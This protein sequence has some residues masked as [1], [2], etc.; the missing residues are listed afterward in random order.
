MRL[1][2]YI[3]VLDDRPAGVGVYIEEVCSRLA[4]RFRDVVVYTGTP[5]ARRP[6]LKGAVV[7]PLGRRLAPWLRGAEGLRRRA[8]RLAWLAGESVLDLR[9]DGVDVLFSPVQESLLVGKTPRV[10]VVHDVTALHYPDAYDA[11]TVAQ[12][13]YLLPLMLRR[14]SRVIAVSENTKRDVVARFGLDPAGIDVVY[15]GYDKAVFRPRSGAEIAEVREKFGLPQR[16]LFYAGTFSRHKN[17]GL[18]VEALAV[19]RDR[20]PD[21]TFVVAGRK[22]AGVAHEVVDRSRALGLEEKVRVLGYVS[23]DE[24]ATLM[25][26]AAVFVYPSRYEG[27]GLAPLEAMACGAPVVASNVASLPEVV[28]QGGVLVDGT[29][30]D[31]W[32]RAVGG[33][34]QGDSSALRGRALRQSAA[35][36]W[37]GAVEALAAIV[38]AA[39]AP[40]AP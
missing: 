9:R 27:F 30:S 10:V 18:V 36:T 19:L 12:T 35:F 13:R 31:A 16:Y 21:L 15:E 2:L 11:G 4:A 39:A 14:A 1:G 8:H 38:L 25:S 22:D 33:V 28:G 29:T 37:E 7:R 20:H 24:L 34:L 26:G 23:R 17:L 6:W 40:R 5:E 32:G 3:P